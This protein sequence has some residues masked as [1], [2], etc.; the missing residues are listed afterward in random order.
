MRLTHPRPKLAPPRQ[1]RPIPILRHPRA[2]I[3]RTHPARVQPRERAQ[4][5]AHLALLRTARPLRVAGREAVEERPGGPA[6]GFD[7]GRTVLV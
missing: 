1:P 7:V 4:E 6:E 2:E 3:V 5:R